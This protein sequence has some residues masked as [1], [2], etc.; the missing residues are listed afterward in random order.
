MLPIFVQVLG[1]DETVRHEAANGNVME[2]FVVVLSVNEPPELAVHVPVVLSDPVTGTVAQPIS[3][4]DTSMSPVNSRHD[5]VTFQVPTT[6]PPQGGVTLEQ[7][8]PPPA[9]LPP[10][11]E[12]PPELAPPP[13][14]EL[15]LLPLHPSGAIM[16]RNISKAPRLHTEISCNCV[17][18]GR[19][20]YIV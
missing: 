17:D 4:K 9:P 6:L 2:P 15:V 7:D 14:P 11:P 20:W 13:A 8:V 12:T 5:D 1:S 10:E 3:S 18:K 19:R 16:P